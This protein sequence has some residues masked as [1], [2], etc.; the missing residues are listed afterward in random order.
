MSV[1]DDDDE[2]MSL[3]YTLR[4]LALNA[5]PKFEVVYTLAMLWLYASATEN[6]L[7]SVRP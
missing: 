7:F 1:V 2:I 4:N 5:F 3:Y 6:I